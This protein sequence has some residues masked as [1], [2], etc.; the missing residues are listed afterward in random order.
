[1][2]QKRVV[3]AIRRQHV[4]RVIAGWEKRLSQYPCPPDG[5]GSPRV[6]WIE[7]HKCAV[8]RWDWMA[9]SSREIYD[10]VNV[11]EL[12][13]LA[14]ELIV[15]GA[16]ALD[17][18]QY[19][20]CPERSG[21]EFPIQLATRVEVRA[22]ERV[23]HP[24]HHWQRNREAADATIGTVI[25]NDRTERQRRFKQEQAEYPDFTPC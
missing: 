3:L 21:E 17:D 20:R 18:V 4:E 8:L 5:I 24:K 25:K 12:E 19:W 10:L 2:K 6:E 23:D 13:M 1:M 16:G 14:Y 11:L 15:V 22:I 7:K 9:L